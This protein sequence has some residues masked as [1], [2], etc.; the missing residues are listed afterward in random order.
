M[1]RLIFHRYIFYKHTVKK[2]HSKEKAIQRMN[3]EIE[4]WM[5]RSPNGLRT[6]HI[7]TPAGTEIT[8]L[9]VDNTKLA[10]WQIID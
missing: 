9:F 1:T 4:N 5:N 7:V 8:S 2:Y 6:E 10:D 3:I